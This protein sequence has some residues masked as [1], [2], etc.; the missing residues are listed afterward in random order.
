MN[1]VIK[2]LRKG[3]AYGLLVFQTHLINFWMF[4]WMDFSTNCLLVMILI[5]KLKWPRLALGLFKLLIDLT[6]GNLKNFKIK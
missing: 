3:S 4:K 1:L 2:Q 6:K 5:T